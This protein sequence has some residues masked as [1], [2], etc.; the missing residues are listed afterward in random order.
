MH[1]AAVPLS[2][3]FLTT[4]RTSSLTDQAEA[5]V[6]TADAG[7]GETSPQGVPCR[8]MTTSAVLLLACPDQPG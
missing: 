5:T 8:P 6:L 7:M 3:V 1:R 4:G 2:E